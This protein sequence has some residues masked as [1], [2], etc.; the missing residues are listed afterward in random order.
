MFGRRKNTGWQ[1]RSEKNE[2]N[3][4]YS[5]RR[6]LPPP[7]DIRKVVQA[8][9]TKS[10]TVTSRLGPLVVQDKENVSP[11]K[12]QGV[13]EQEELEQ[14]S[15]AAGVSRTFAPPVTV[16][17]PN[18]QPLGD[19]C[20]ANTT[21]IGDKTAKCFSNPD[22]KWLVQLFER[23]VFQTITNRVV[24]G[25]ITVMRRYIFLMIGSN[26]VF[27]ATKAKIYND[28]NM[29]TMCISNKNTVAK[30]FVAGVLPRPAKDEYAKYYIITMNR[31]LAAAAKKIQK[32]N[33]RVFYIP[34]QLQF[35]DPKEYDYLFEEDRL[36]LN[37]F[38]K[39]CLKRAL[40]EGAGFIQK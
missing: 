3:C 35:Q 13:V 2:G 40:L 37:C 5:Y 15:L 29:L 30:I 10:V 33:T 4:N 19:I 32:Q 26:Q 17:P 24:S 9:A 31:F 36:Q 18:L 38:G 23:A 27:R 12:E 6:M 25:E 11:R 16:L 22:S 34:V 8:N 39:M 14:E 28:L 7:P 20:L 1:G 21:L